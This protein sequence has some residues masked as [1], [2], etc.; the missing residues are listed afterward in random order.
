MHARRARLHEGRWPVARKR[1]VQLQQAHVQGGLVEGMRL[2]AA[3]RHVARREP[4]AQLRR[5]LPH[6]Q[7][8]RTLHPVPRGTGTPRPSV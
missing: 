1:R 3:P 7:L 2:R 5:L 6:A 4:R 8:V